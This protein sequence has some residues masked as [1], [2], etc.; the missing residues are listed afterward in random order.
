MRG[1]R[2]DVAGR[3]RHAVRPEMQI[4]VNCAGLEFVG[5]TPSGAL[6]SAVPALGLVIRTG[7][8]DDGRVVAVDIRPV[9]AL[10]AELTL[11]ASCDCGSEGCGVERARAVFRKAC[12]VAERRAN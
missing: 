9:A 12:D 2:R 10:R 11:P 8:E 3:A 4:S 7:V 1:R 6:V 5:K